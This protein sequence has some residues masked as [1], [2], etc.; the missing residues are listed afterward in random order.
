MLSKRT[1]VCKF[2]VALVTRDF[3]R[4]MRRICVLDLA[5]LVRKTSVAFGAF[6]GFQ[7]LRHDVHGLKEQDQRNREGQTLDEEGSQAQNEREKPFC[8]K[9]RTRD[10]PCCQIEKL[11]PTKQEKNAPQATHSTN[12]ILAFIKRFKHRIV[13]DS[14]LI[15]GR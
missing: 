15:W 10:S 2:A 9:R 13:K 3:S 7:S 6:V 8:E 5:R 4:S 11:D 12:P 14:R 1:I